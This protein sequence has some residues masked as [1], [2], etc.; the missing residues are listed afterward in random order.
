MAGS[1][2]D[3]VVLALQPLSE[4]ALALLQEADGGT[5]NAALRLLVAP[6]P[7]DALADCIEVLDEIEDRWRVA[8]EPAANRQNRTFD[9]G[10]ILAHRSVLPVLVAALVL[11]P[12]AGKHR[13]MVEPLAPQVAPAVFADDGGVGRQRS[14]VE[15]SAAPAEIVVEQTTAI[16]VRIDR[17]AIVGRADRDD[18]FEPR[19]AAGGDLQPVEAAPGYPDHAGDARAPLFAAQMLDDF[20]RIVLLALDIFV[21]DDAVGIAHPGNID[22]R[23]G[24]PIR[25]EPQMHLV[26][27]GARAVAAAIGDVFENERY[28][29]RVGGFGEK[30]AGSEAAPVRHGNPMRLDG[31]DAGNS[32]ACH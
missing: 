23:A 6:R 32:Y 12:F 7:G 5:G 26:I 14:V 30:Q 17:I 21:F 9:R 16:V 22:A 10:K 15:E 31:S 8:V 27:A 4:P 11:Q 18:A 25:G 20:Q 29:L 24:K 13:M 19:R 1:S 2:G 28:R 3:A